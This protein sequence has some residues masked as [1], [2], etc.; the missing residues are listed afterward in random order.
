MRVVHP[1][2]RNHWRLNIWN[3]DGFEFYHLYDHPVSRVTVSMD[4]VLHR[5][6]SISDGSVQLRT[7]YR[8]LGLTVVLST[9]Q[10]TWIGSYVSVQ[11]DKG[12][13]RTNEM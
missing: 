13:M 6:L 4:L 9:I 7:G 2:K 1:C 11:T 3:E 5:Q 12:S 8:I 10:I